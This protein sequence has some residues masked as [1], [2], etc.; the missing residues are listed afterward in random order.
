MSQEGRISNMK[1]AEVGAFKM[2]WQDC[3]G[4]DPI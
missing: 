2:D 4:G 3:L 1:Q